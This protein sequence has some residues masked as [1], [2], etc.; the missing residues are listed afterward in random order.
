MS[1]VWLGCH[2]GYS[3]TARTRSHT[4]QRS[5]IINEGTKLRS[6]ESHKS[7]MLSCWSSDPYFGCFYNGNET[8]IDHSTKEIVFSWNLHKFRASG[9]CL[10]SSGSLDGNIQKRRI[11]NTFSLNNVYFFVRHQKFILIILALTFDLYYVHYMYVHNIVYTHNIV[12]RLCSIHFNHNLINH[13]YIKFSC[14]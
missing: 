10:I 3:I 11:K 13:K 6:P 1:N 4:L 7:L 12:C 14:V 2:I 9:A 5:I 8:N